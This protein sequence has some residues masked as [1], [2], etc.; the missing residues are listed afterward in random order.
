[1]MCL[2]MVWLFFE[3]AELLDGF[4]QGVAA[5]GDEGGKLLGFRT[6]G[7]HIEHIYAAH[8]VVNGVDHV[9]QILGQLDDVLPLD[10][11]DEFVRK[12]LG[13]IVAETI[14]GVFNVVHHFQLFAASFRR[15]I[16]QRFFQVFRR[17]QA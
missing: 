12:H 14:R 10:G 13:H 1:M 17:L 16:G 2:P 3:V 6:D 7:L 5:L 4:Q 11:G 9:V 8:H 15:K